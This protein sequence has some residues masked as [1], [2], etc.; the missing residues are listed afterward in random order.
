[1]NRMSNAVSVTTRGS[2]TVV[3]LNR[4]DV[5]N[6]VDADTAQ[7]LYDGETDTAQQRLAQAVPEV[8]P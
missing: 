1:M 8:T 2:I 4:P 7:L 5:R 3:T 6:A